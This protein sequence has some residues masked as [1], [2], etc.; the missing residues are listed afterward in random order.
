MRDRSS[1]P[2]G[3]NMPKDSQRKDL[4]WLKRILRTHFPDFWRRTIARAE[5]RGSH[6]RKGGQ[7]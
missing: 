4:T 7:P 6:I 3:E 5:T 2:E 1:G